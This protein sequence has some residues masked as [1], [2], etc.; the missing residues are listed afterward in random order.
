MSL[1]DGIW[2]DNADLAWNWREKRDEGLE[3][4]LMKRN[5]LLMGWKDMMR[6]SG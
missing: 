2:A 6:S 3:V 5:E 4:V 1:E